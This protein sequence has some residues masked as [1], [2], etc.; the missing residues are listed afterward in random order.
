MT[1]KQVV[2]L[3]EPVLVVRGEF[4]DGL[5]EVVGRKVATIAK[6]AHE[7]VLAIRFEF[8]RHTDPAVADPV[9]VHASVDVNGRLVHATATGRGAR[10]AL[11]LAVDRVTRQLDDRP[12]AH[13]RQ[14]R[15]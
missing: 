4:G 12:H 1:A 3:P 7:P 6:H 11:D 15:H 9:T 13:R 10:D 8:D 14:R 2:E 5:V